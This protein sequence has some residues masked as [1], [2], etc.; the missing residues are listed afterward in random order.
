MG[1][2]YMTVS[3]DEFETPIEIADS[4]KELAAILGVKTN[5]VLEEASRNYHKK[6]STSGKTRG[7]R[8]M[9]VFD[10]NKDNSIRKDILPEDVK[11]YDG[12]GY[13]DSMIADI[14]GCSTTTVK[15][16]R[17]QYVVRE[18]SRSLYNG[19]AK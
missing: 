12:L 16:R 5:R 19:I 6:K 13:S 15:N 7:Y 4:A 11:Y 2:I 18:K 14:L 1:F 9:K 8:I 10:G 3:A 17:N